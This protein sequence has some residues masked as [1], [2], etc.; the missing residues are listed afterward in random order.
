MKNNIKIYLI[1]GVPCS[2]KTWVF[3]QL[4]KNK[5][6]QGKYEHLAHDDYI[7]KDYVGSIKE[8]CIRLCSSSKSPRVVIIETPFSPTK[9]G[10]PLKT[11]GLQVEEVYLTPGERILR[12]NNENRGRRLKEKEL[13]QN[14]TFLKRAQENNCF[15]GDALSVMIYLTQELKGF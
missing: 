8:K 6:L 13:K 14:Q 9:L 2:G 10:T 4:A 11:E 1:A 5:T 7:G 3:E 12:G 15:H